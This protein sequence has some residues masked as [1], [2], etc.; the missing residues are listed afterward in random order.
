MIE[1]LLSKLEKVSSKGRGKW[2]ACC[3]G[4]PDKNPSLGITQTDDDRILIHCFSGC[5]ALEILDSIGL[6]FDDL[7]PKKMEG[8]PFKR[9]EKRP[10]STVQIM[11]AFQIELLIGVQ[12]LGG[13][14]RSTLTEADKVLAGATAKNLSKFAGVLSR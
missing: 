7:Y 12:L 9:G 11:S 14:S 10:F 3:P 2:A 13:F 1:N 8:S 5:S 6:N 4:H